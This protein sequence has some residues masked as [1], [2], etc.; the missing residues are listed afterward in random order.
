MIVHVCDRCGADER[1]DVLYHITMDL[2]AF[3]A[4]LGKQDFELCENCIIDILPE[5]IFQYKDTVED[6]E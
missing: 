6:D 1:S 5:D 4:E 2:S 3:S